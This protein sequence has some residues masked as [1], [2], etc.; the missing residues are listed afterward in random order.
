MVAMATAQN[1]IIF[2]NNI[3]PDA[4]EVVFYVK[5]DSLY[6][7][8]LFTIRKIEIY[9]PTECDSYDIFKKESTIPLKNMLPGRYSV[10]VFTNSKIIMMSFVK[11]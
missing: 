11:R 2:V 8:S 10:G 5:D 4:K 7:T 9:K 3:N 1:N 6:I